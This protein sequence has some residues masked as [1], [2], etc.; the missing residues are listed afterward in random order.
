MIRVRADSAS[1]YKGRKSHRDGQYECLLHQVARPGEGRSVRDC[2]RDICVE[3]WALGT[4]S[5]TSM[6]DPKVD[7]VDGM[8]A[9]EP[10]QHLGF[11]A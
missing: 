6:Q 8:N 1:A 10:V 4:G 5:G 9:N 3:R 7:H 2:R 11:A